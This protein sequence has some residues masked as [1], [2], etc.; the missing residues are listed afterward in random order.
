MYFN[1]TISSI[2]W[3]GHISGMFLPFYT[4]RAV[5]YQ[6]E[7]RT[8][9]TWANYPVVRIQHQ[10]P[11]LV[12]LQFFNTNLASVQLF[13]CMRFNLEYFSNN[14]FNNRSSSV[15]ESTLNESYVAYNRGF[16]RYKI[17]MVDTDSFIFLRRYRYKDF[18]LFSTISTSI[19]HRYTSAFLQRSFH[20][21][22]LPLWPRHMPALSFK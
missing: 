10:N 5:I 14:T 19:G 7:R 8:I 4:A 15:E 1:T 11:N 13:L 20:S 22:C 9:N 6:F 12:L 18:F 3:I 16:T 2:T 21:F 17:S